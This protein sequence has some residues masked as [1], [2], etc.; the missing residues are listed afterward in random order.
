MITAPAVDL[1]TA[2]ADLTINRGGQLTAAQGGV[3]VLVRP[4]MG[5]VLTYGLQGLLLV[6]LGVGG[7]VLAA[8]TSD[9]IATL[10]ISILPVVLLCL[11]VVISW[12]LVRFLRHRGM[13]LED[14]QRGV[15]H[16][17]FGRVVW[18][19]FRRENSVRKSAGYVAEISEG[20]SPSQSTRLHAEAA[21]LPPGPY[22][23]YFLPGSRILIAAESTVV[24]GGAWSI[25]SADRALIRERLI[26]WQDPAPPEPLP[27]PPHIGD[28]AE[29]LRALMSAMGF[30]ATALEQARSD[31]ASRRTAAI[32]GVVSRSM[33]TTHSQD[34]DG[35]QVS[36]SHHFLV[37]QGKT[38]KIS[39][40]TYRAVVPSLPYRV[41]FAPSSGR[42]LGLELL[43]M[44]P[45]APLPGAPGR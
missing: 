33:H 43:Q 38:F 6:A 1:A 32:E 9:G 20:S 27:A 24:P 17:A 5:V 13:L 30:G 14:L 7:I 39:G 10:V 18:G 26:G 31:L 8:R 44:H 28:P 35:R 41:Y 36:S 12:R 15:V 42:L 37:V 4:A 16:R 29:L 22:W 45:A 23:F 11:G 34:S 25:S 2:Q 19:H 40:A 3:L 21:P